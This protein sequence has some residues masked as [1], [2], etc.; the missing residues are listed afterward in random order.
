MKLPQ[1]ILSDHIKPFIGPNV[2]FDFIQDWEDDPD[3]V[4]VL[5]WFMTHGLVD[6]YQVSKTDWNLF[7]WACFHNH[8][9]IIDL[10]I[11][12]NIDL[13]KLLRPTIYIHKSFPAVDCFMN[14]LDIV[15]YYNRLDILKKL[16]AYD[17]SL[18]RPTN[19]SYACEMNHVEMCEFLVEQGI[20]L[21]PQLYISA[22]RHN[23]VRLFRLLKEKGCPLDYRGMS[24][25]TVLMYACMHECPEIV[26]DLCDPTCINTQDNH[27]NSALMYA[28]MHLIMHDFK[29]NRKSDETTKSEIVQILLDRGVDVNLQKKSG[30]T[31]LFIA[32]KN[33]YYKVASLL[34]EKGADLSIQ[35]HSGWNC[36]MY[37]CHSGDRGAAH[38][39]LQN[40][41]DL[42]QT[43]KDGMNALMFACRYKRR[44]IFHLIM[45]HA[46]RIHLNAHDKTGHTALIWACLNTP[47][48]YMI[49]KLVR[50][51]ADALRKTIYGATALQMAYEYGAD[52]NILAMLLP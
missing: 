41:V 12:N 20:A 47:D 18:I 36:L 28:C 15:A 46:E 31:A 7:S 34:L 19:L 49:R 27:G 10:L 43:N 17:P 26:R 22:C 50:K 35:D 5:R 6:P 39:I 51:G 30:I 24:G 21:D 44:E 13:Q 40:G 52:E 29:K 1:E 14:A 23:N 33:H 42:H 9:R 38:L 11:E 32:F 45:E 8:H 3:M 37:A 48:A 25:R 16:V 2:L 4:I